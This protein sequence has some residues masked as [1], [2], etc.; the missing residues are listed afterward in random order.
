MPIHIVILFNHLPNKST[1]VPKSF[2]EYGSKDMPQNFVNNYTQFATVERRE[3]RTNGKENFKKPWKC[4]IW[5]Y[6]TKYF[7]TK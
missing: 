1:I 2:R 6:S 7:K 5:E 4:T 3:K